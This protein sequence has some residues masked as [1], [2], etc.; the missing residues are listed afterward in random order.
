[1]DVQNNFIKKTIINIKHNLT[2][3]LASTLGLTLILSVQ[4]NA[5][6]IP[7]IDC[8]IE[9][10]TVVNLSSPVS[11][12]LDT[13]MVDR[14]DVVSK[15]QIVAT[16]K[17]DLE[18]LNVKTST[19]N[20]RLSTKEYQRAVELYREKAI[21]LSE[22]EKAEHEKKLYEL[23]LKN[24]RATLALR[25]VRSPIDGVVV[26]R[27]KMPGEYV[28]DKPILKIA[29]LDPLRIEVVS[30]VENF[31]KIKKG[32]H[33]QITPEY[34]EFDDLI[35]EI[36]VVDQ[37]ID[38]ASGTFGIRLELK[39]EGNKVPGGLKCKVRFFT[40]EEDNKY[41]GKSSE[42]KVAA[43]KAATVPESATENSLPSPTL[44]TIKLTN[45][46]SARQVEELSK[47]TEEVLSASAIAMANA[48]ARA[49]GKAPAATEAIPQAPVKVAE[50]KADYVPREKLSQS[51]VDACSSIGMYKDRKEL[52]KAIN[53][54]GDDVIASHIREE[55]I[56]E[57]TYLVQSVMLQEL[58]DARILNAEIR[59]KGVTDTAIIPRPVDK[60][61]VALGLYSQRE[62]AE[63]QQ[64]KLKELGIETAIRPRSN[65]KTV[66][67][68]DMATIRTAPVLLELMETKTNKV[69]KSLLYKTCNR[70]ELGL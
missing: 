45:K 12:V 20:L 18:E 59:E 17:S 19:E 2:G 3:T 24:S 6:P 27:Y 66:Y 40:E 69:G 62:T 21:T 9:P 57:K 54:L 48:K 10:K 41:T 37:V 13:I 36:I 35:A 60:F 52:R 47:K 33:A 26:D 15:N 56:E 42:K 43:K 25:Q 44:K 30:T 46:S 49:S 51:A 29:Q 70:A 64:A 16:L 14:S 28:E 7:E 4:V 8:L 38:A 65:K 39:N 63:A 32:M 67:W 58:E 53:S 1:M 23:E 34:G 11:G 50:T 68:A 31:G 5:E 61:V 22:K 55:V